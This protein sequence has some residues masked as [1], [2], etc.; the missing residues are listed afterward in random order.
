MKCMSVACVCVCLYVDLWINMCV[1]VCVCVYMCLCVCV[2][3]CVCIGKRVPM[4]MCVRMNMFHCVCVHVCTPAHALASVCDKSAGLKS[5]SSPAG[6]KPLRWRPYRRPSDVRASLNTPVSRHLSVS[7]SPVLW[8]LAAFISP[9]SWE[10]VSPSSPGLSGT[11]S[12]LS[13]SN[14]SVWKHLWLG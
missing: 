10:P 13:L 4:P 3:V 11:G 8:P 9:C 7:N 6:V 5:P 2:C 14:L 1:C 12:G